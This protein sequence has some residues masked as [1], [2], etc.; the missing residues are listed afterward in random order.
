MTWRTC[1]RESRCSIRHTAFRR[2]FDSRRPIEAFRRSTQTC[3]LVTKVHSEAIRFAQQ[4]YTIVLIGHSGHD[5][6]V[7]T[8]G[9]APDAVRLV[10]TLEDCD[11]VEVADPT[12]VAYLTQTTLSMNDAKAIVERL[13]ERFP[14]IVGPMRDDICYATQ[15]RQEAVRLLA[16]DADL[17]LVIGSSN[18]SNSRRL[19]ELG[20][21]VW[22]GDSFD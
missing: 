3:P 17:V 21:F 13:R 11:R 7:G 5:E 20:Q 15:N 8:M 18:S 14:E 6:V 12:K 16:G 10:T 19:A 1:R 2:P 4:G 9:E 22:S